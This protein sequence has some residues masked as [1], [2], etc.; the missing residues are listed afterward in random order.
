MASK[1]SQTIRFAVGSPNDVR[2]YVWRLWVTGNEVYL[3]ARDL[4]RAF[5]VSLH[6]SGVWRVAEVE[7]LEARDTN[8]D[9]L[10]FRWRR[11]REFRPGCT[12]S[13][14]VVI[15][16]IEPKDPFDPADP[17]NDPRIR[18]LDPPRPGEKLVV[19]VFF[20]KPSVSEAEI[21]HHGHLNNSIVGRLSKR[22][23]EVVWLRKTKGGLTLFELLKFSDTMS[24]L[25]IHLKPGGTPDSLFRARAILVIAKDDPKYYNQPTI[26][27]IPLGKEHVVIDSRN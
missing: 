23:G 3:G 12:S 7:N 11:P 16:P 6:H 15:S 13:L 27:D 14:A 22:S 19:Q 26:L 4:L 25:Q 8:K 5:K 10:I 17:E 2:S 9:R 18:W 21:I 20:S 24:K 1:E